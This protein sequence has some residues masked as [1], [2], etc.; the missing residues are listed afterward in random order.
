ME[1]LSPGS[2][3]EAVEMLAG[4]RHTVLAGGTDFFPARAGR[5]ST[6]PVVDITRVGELRGIA[7]HEDHFRIGALTSWAEIAASDL[8]R[9]FDGLRT[10]AGRVGSIQ[11]QNAGTVGGNLC[12]ASPAADGVPPLLA[13]DAS[14]ELSSA[15]GRRIVLLEDFI[16]GYRQTDLQPGELLT[17]VLVPRQ[18]EHAASAFEK[19]GSR[20]YLVISIAMVAVLVAID[21]G[22]RVTAARVAIGACSP[23]AQRA[24]ALEADLVGRMVDEPLEDLVTTDHLS[25]LSPIDDIRA[26][27]SY[28][29][30]AAL[31]LTRR[32]LQACLEQQ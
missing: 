23:V 22:R 4:G 20:R 28:R 25:M 17:A 2:L 14:I 26:S 12:N 31:M 1:Y 16:V 24:R 27:A 7:C 8:P 21:P 5:P 19:L 30:H 15:S 6:E 32:T 29:R 13:L 9:G 10:A 3:A 11:V 18:F